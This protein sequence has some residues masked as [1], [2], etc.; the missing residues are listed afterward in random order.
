MSMTHRRRSGH[1]GEL[2]VERRL[3]VSG[4]QSPR[5]RRQRANPPTP[6]AP[7]AAGDATLVLVLERR[8]GGGIAVVHDALL[9]DSELGAMPVAA[10]AADSCRPV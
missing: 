6:A 7:A 10:A 1:P 4:G 2:L 9:G 3:A 8:V 5:E